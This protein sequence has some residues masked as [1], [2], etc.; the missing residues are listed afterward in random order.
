MKLRSSSSTLQGTL[1]TIAPC[2]SFNDNSAMSKA[3]Q[4]P[5][6]LDVI[7]A[8]L[9]LSDLKVIR[10]VC[11][12]WGDVGAGLLGKRTVLNVNQL[13]RYDGSKLYQATPVHDTLLRSVIIRDEFDPS[14]PARR[15]DDVITQVFSSNV[16]QVTR[17]VAFHVTLKKYATAFLNGLRSLK[18][19]SH[20]QHI[21]IL[22]RS[23]NRNLDKCRLQALRKLPIQHDLTSLKFQIHPRMRYWGS[24]IHSF[25]PLLQVL[26]DVSP[27]LTSLDVT[28]SLCP[29][30]EGCKSLKV[31]KFS[32]SNCNSFACPGFKLTTVTTML[33]P[34]KDSLIELELSYAD[35]HGNDSNSQ[36][37]NL[38]APIMSNLTT[39]TLD[40]PYE[41][42]I[43]DFF[44]VQHLPKLKNLSL[45]NQEIGGLT[46]LSIHLNLWKR[47][48]GVESLSLKTHGY[49][50]TGDKYGEQIVGLFPTVKK[51]ELMLNPCEN[52]VKE[53]MESLQLWDLEEA[54]L[55]V[56]CENAASGVV[57]ILRNM[58]RC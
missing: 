40:A 30:L 51:L 37:R 54:K 8:Q 13:I 27:S 9:D 53:L 23:R 39:L 32:F 6:V 26:I 18:E 15:T 49:C 10:L 58:A 19:T 45:R 43:P 20:I 1:S 35:I 5:L 21:T 36:G 17:E 48:P 11:R 46:G 2:N 57:G 42:L 31:L 25:Q 44:D 52:C 4:N 7:F 50:M 55:V 56:R 14:I 3:L 12:E 28:A 16:S 41:Y 47:H 33:T 24:G 38:D 34:V 29:S 22:I